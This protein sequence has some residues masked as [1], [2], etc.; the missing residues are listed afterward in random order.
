VGFEPDLLELLTEL[1]DA[2]VESIVIGGFA[3]V[4]HG[5]PHVTFDLDLVHRRT[6]ANVDRLL[7]VLPKIDAYAR[8]RAPG[9]R[10][11]PGREAL[12]GP[13]HQ[14]LR[15]R[16]GAL[17]LLGAL[18]DEGYDELL[19]HSTTVV[20]RGRSVRIVDLDKLIDLKRRANREKDRLVLPV[21]MALAERQKA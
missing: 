2:G 6:S 15:T 21:L 19:P 10:L 4:A 5:A 11:V 18:D 12:S 7:A 14:L 1:A 17:D 9:E 13:G 3:A 8:G 20:L 16:Y